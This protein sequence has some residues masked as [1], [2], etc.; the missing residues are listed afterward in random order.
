MTDDKTYEGWTNRETWLVNLCLTIME[1]TAT[2][3]EI[4]SIFRDQ[5]R[6]EMKD[7]I[8]RILSTQILTNANQ[9]AIISSL[10]S[11]LDASLKFLLREEYNEEMFQDLLKTMAQEEYDLLETNF[12]K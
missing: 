4:A 1:N 7:I 3:L 6:I 5:Y 9:V 10:R 12:N 8:A 11:L 2:D